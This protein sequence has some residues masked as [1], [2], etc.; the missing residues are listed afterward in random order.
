MTPEQLD[1]FMKIAGAAV[2]DIGFPVFVA[3]WLL[4]RV[5]PAMRRLTEAIRD[6]REVNQIAAGFTRRARDPKPLEER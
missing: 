5:E 3:L 1:A 4:L 2:R 6:L